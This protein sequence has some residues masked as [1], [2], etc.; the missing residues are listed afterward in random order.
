MSWSFSA[1]GTPEEVSQA[2]ETSPNDG[3]AEPD[4]TEWTEAK[5]ALLSLVD[6]NKGNRINLTA[7]GHGAWA[8][9]KRVQG[10]C[11]CRLTPV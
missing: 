10:N 5:P 8:D 3:L 1:S 2:I 4:L 6:A 11:G 7:T 9:G